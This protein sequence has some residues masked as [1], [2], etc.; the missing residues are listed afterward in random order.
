MCLEMS[1]NKSLQERFLTP[2]RNAVPFVRQLSARFFVTCSASSIV[3]PDAI[4]AHTIA[5]ADEPA[6]GVVS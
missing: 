4:T 6:N 2:R 3:F 1:Q 5:P